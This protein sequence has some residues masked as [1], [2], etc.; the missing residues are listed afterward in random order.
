MKQTNFTRLSFKLEPDNLLFR[1]IPI[2]NLSIF[3]I[4]LYIVNSYRFV[5]FVMLS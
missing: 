2:C 5:G 4:L 1:L 3:A